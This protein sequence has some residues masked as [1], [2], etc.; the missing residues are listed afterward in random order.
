MDILIIAATQGEIAA[1]LA[2][3][4]QGEHRIEF[5]VT[6]IGM[7]ATAYHLGR[8]LAA[9]RPSLLLNVGVCGSFG[10]HHALGDVV[11]VAEDTFAELGAED[12]GA[13]LSGDALGF[14][15][16]TFAERLDGPWPVLAGLP[17]VTGITVNTVHG[18]DASIGRIVA[19]LSPG[20]ESMEGAAVFYAAHQAQVQCLQV[21]AISNYVER[22]QRDNW[23]LEKAIANL[24]KWL[25][26]FLDALPV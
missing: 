11:R 18:D 24:N 22:R 14:G 20:V 3:R 1:S 5:L 4:Y 13:F 26:D 12:G 6:G 2:Q 25:S 16:C 9:R 8:V 17:T 15:P 10:R 19:R 7:T 21:R 23:E